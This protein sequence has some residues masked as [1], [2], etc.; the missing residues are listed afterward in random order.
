MT[1]K[2]GILVAM[3]QEIPPST[4]KE[5]GLQHIAIIG[6]GKVNASIG[7][8]QLLHAQPQLEILIN[9]GTAGA[10]HK[11]VGEVLRCS[12]FIQRDF[13]LPFPELAHYNQPIS[14]QSSL[15]NKYPHLT[16]HHH[17]CSTGDNFVHLDTHH[18]QIAHPFDCLEMEA[19]AIAKVCQLQQKQFL[20]LKYISDNSDNASKDDWA[21]SLQGKA[22]SALSEELKNLLISLR[23]QS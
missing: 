3:D 22:K 19:Y 11:T 12:N 14:F 23:A 2:I 21:E 1:N 5:L 20:A 10:V 7:A 6:V 9:V 13:E 18:A 17:T 4:L 15:S 8:M 16:N